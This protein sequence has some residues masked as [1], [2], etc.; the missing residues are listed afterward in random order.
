MTTEIDSSSRSDRLRSAVAGTFHQL[1]NVSIRVT[2]DGASATN[3]QFYGASTTREDRIPVP[4]RAPDRVAQPLQMLN[5]GSAS[6]LT[7][8]QLVN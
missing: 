8:R 5:A 2:D 6:H 4:L 1:R 7:E 3:A